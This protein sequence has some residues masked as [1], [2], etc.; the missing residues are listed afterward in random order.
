MIDLFY[1]CKRF[2]LLL[3]SWRGLLND[4][5]AEADWQ[6]MNLLP[7]F[8][9]HHYWPGNTVLIGM[10]TP[11]CLTVLPNHLVLLSVVT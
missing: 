3:P 1:D 10:S 8:V 9:V 6:P 2:D 11:S 4:I 5:N 7:E